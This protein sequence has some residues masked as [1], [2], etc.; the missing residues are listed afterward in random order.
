[1]DYLLDQLAPILE[2]SPDVLY[3]WARRMPPDLEP[4]EHS[5]PQRIAAAYQAFRRVL[6][7]SAAGKSR[8]GGKKR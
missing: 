3:F 7:Q 4:D 6:R 2:L 5:D 8:A 1:M